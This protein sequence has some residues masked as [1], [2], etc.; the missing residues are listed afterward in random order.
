[1]RKQFAMLA[2]LLAAGAAHAGKAHQHGVAQMTVAVDGNVLEIEFVSPMENLVG[3]EHAPRN[4]RERKAVQAL[5]ER[6]GKPQALLVPTAAA[7]CSVEPAEL[8]LPADRDG[9]GHADMRATIVFQ[10]EKP[11]ALKEIGVRLFD[12]FPRLQRV[13]VQLAAAGRQSAAELSR[14]RVSLALPNGR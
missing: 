13:Q 2:M 3:F 6:F 7:G 12:A 14:Q 9:G 5:K 10:C 1:M 4:D 11:A 8:E